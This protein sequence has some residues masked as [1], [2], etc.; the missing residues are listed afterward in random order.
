[1]GIE[2]VEKL[3][4]ECRKC[5]FIDKPFLT[6]GVYERYRG[7]AIEVL[8]ISESPPPGNKP[9]FLYN[10]GHRDRLRKVL[11]K[12]LGIEEER[13]L[14]EMRNR[15]VLWDMAARCRPP[16]KRDVVAM[17]MNC[18]SVTIAEIEALKPRTVIALGTVARKQLSRALSACSYKPVEVY[19]ERHPLYVVRF[20]KSEAPKYFA[21]LGKAM[22]LL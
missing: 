18:T 10:T 21:K 3:V 20:A 17:A 11:S 8:V 12:Y 1:L 5:R 9:D 16:S 13:L 2:I 4:R 14:E 19:E 6:H 7:I 22:K 15:G